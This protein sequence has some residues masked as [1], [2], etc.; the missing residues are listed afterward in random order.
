MTIEQAAAIRVKWKQRVEHSPCEHLN[1]ELERND[2]GHSTG[3]YV[4]IICGEPIAQKRL[5][6]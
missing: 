4:C 5:D 6:A 2:L 1:L 3:N